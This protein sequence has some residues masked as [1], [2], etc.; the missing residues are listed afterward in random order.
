MTPEETRRLGIEFERRCQ[1]FDP[2]LQTVGKLDTEDIYSFL[3]QYQL[4]FV[5]QLYLTQDKLQNGTYTASKIRDYL[6]SL[7]KRDPVIEVKTITEYNLPGAELPDKYFMYIAS[8]THFDLTVIQPNELVDIKT[9]NDIQNMYFDRHRIIRKPLI[10]IVDNNKVIIKA[11]DGLTPTAITMDYIKKPSEFTILGDD[12]KPC[13]L[14]SDCF[15]DLV[16]G[17]VELFF[18]YKYKVSLARNA[19]KKKAKQHNN[20]DKEDKEDSDD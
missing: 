19:A 1:T 18:N 11:M 8:F 20:K 15:E 6:K 16:N 12:P 7:V 14:P 4:Q 2:S 5:K 10:A 3:N 13:E 17:A 9:I